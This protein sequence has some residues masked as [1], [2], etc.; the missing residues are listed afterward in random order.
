MSLVKGLDVNVDV[1]VDEDVGIGLDA[2][3]YCDTE[4]YVEKKVIVEMDFIL[5]P[6][7]SS[8]AV[9]RYKWA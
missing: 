9:A 4:L 2:D 3:C 6:H 5:Y 1:D 8:R 7:N